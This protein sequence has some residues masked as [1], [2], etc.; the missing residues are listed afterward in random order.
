M[1]NAELYGISMFEQNAGALIEQRYHPSTSSLFRAG[2]LSNPL[3]LMLYDG[4][5]LSLV[6][7][8]I[9]PVVEAVADREKKPLGECLLAPEC[10]QGFGAG[11]GW[12]AEEGSK[13][14]R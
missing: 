13:M 10:E 9:V 2:H 1:F 5:I 11:W 8:N 14:Q 4:I 7:H 3:L 6:L 12:A